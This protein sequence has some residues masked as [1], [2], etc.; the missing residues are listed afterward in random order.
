M[1]SRSRQFTFI[2]FAVCLSLTARSDS[3]FSLLQFSHELWQTEQGLPQNTVQ[4]LLQTRDG[5]V[6]L[7]TREGLARFDGI[8]FT[9]FDKHNTLQ[10]PHNQIRHLYEDRD[11][12]LWI[13]TPGG[14]LRYERGV[15]TAYTTK[16]GLASNNVWSV[17]QDRAGNLWVATVNGLNQFRDGK[18]TTFTTAQGLLNDSI[19]VIRE[20][21][22]GALWIGTEGGLSRYKDGAFT[23]FTK[24]N[25]LVG[26][27]VKTLFVDQ[28]S[29]LWIGTTEGLSVMANSKFI[30]Y[31]TREGLIHNEVKAIA[32]D[33]TNTLWIGTPRG[34]MRFRDGKFAAVTS[35]EGFNDTPIL[36]LLKDREGSLWVG[37]ETNGLHVLRAKK[38][39]T[40]T[41]REGLSANVVRSIF[42]DRNGQVWVGT[43]RGLNLLR[44]GQ[45]AQKSLP[46]DDVMAM[47]DDSEGNLW[48]G[49]TDGL[50]RIKGASITTFTERDGL[51]D[52]FIRSL[53]TGRDGS[54]W[55]GTR[56]G[57]THFRNGQF[58]PYTMLD[59]LPSDLVGALYED[60]A[61]A[62]WI[63]TLAGLSRF[64][65]EKFTN[66]NT[67]SGLS[68]EVVISL[69][70]DAG[71]ALWIG[72]LGG[73]LNRFKDGKFTSF[74]TK[75]GLPD[76]AIYQI[77]EDAQNNLW[78]S[79]NKGIIR[80]SR[81]ELEA[82][83]DPA[84]K[85]KTVMTFGTADG[86]ETRE[87]SGGGHPAGWKT[88]DG[89][90]WFATIKGVAMI[91]P[92]N[93]KLNQQPPPIAI[94][95][96]VVDDREV[97][98]NAPIT[99]SPEK[100]R[101][102]FYYTGLSFI[103]PN[104]VTF[105]Y[106]LEGFDPDW[107]EAGTRRVA[108]YTNIPAGQ[109]RFVVRACNNDGVWSESAASVEFLLQPR[110]YQTWWFYAVCLLSLGLCVWLW[111]RL[112]V[113]RLEGHFAAIL[114]ER[115]R[116]AREIH[117][118]LAQGFAG[119]SVQLELVARLLTKA[120]D[121]AKPHL[122][123]ARQ[124]VRSSL[125]EAR[126]SV[127]ALRSQSLEN[128]DL[129]SALNETVK[130]LLTN[131]PIQSQV[132]VSGTYRQLS[133]AIE[134]HLLRIGQE[135][136]TNAIKH[137]NALHLR[138]ELSYVTDCVKLR[139]QDDGRGF[140]TTHGSP[141][142]HFGLV[143]MRER[144]AQ[145]GGQLIINSRQNAG[146]EIIVEVPLSAH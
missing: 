5:Y 106:K 120:P 28:Q 129:P 7:G 113:K 145:M 10:I 121:A 36:S 90:L 38:F 91:D 74:T 52:R 6:W 126:R 103:A 117:D 59:G 54:L 43:E 48:V 132:Q 14:L 37:T 13:A 68:N 64:K 56:R 72:T 21:K 104:K 111:Y 49:T 76:D 78:M 118:T 89:K 131:T 112:R 86:M 15:F 81:K 9:I 96:V 65:D 57:L 4:T 75:D 144:V 66:Y 109:Y 100:A 88:A 23:S 140:D 133:H 53:H 143:G 30:S 62:L 130:Q 97:A 46:N 19:E 67:A 83:T 22:D 50:K 80:V 115:T 124:L 107:I 11:G 63:G 20:D 98:M 42:G 141:D 87:C 122:D 125:D 2:L 45:V 71:G 73:G 51:S 60:R 119:I 27:A 82:R 8:R 94:E 12:R 123:Q 47:S 99:L 25:G 29:H 61:G 1:L 95:R 3:G 16:D 39:T 134:D 135:A 142:G 34:L 114:A 108:W 137:A 55:I 105:K 138:V 128:S 26:N 17:F 102:E 110:F 18:F 33:Q 101:F 79:S 77:L 40:F 92:A 31:T 44:N 85:L 84:Q 24:Q 32:E 69:Y 116:I 139:V 70:E 146:T 127:W 35:P 136:I 58:T 41:T 93:L